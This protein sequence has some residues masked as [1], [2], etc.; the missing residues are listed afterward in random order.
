M[1]IDSVTSKSQNY[2]VSNDYISKDKIRDKI[3][4]L[5]KK[6][7][8]YAELYDTVVYWE[9]IAQLQLLKELLEEN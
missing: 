7:K 4:E 8:I 2:T 3:K 6:E 9:I 5:E 1:F